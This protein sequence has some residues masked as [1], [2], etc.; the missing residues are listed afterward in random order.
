MPKQKTLTTEEYGKMASYLWDG[1]WLQGSRGW[2]H[3]PSCMASWPI[4]EAY[5]MAKRDEADGRRMSAEDV[6]EY[7]AGR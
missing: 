4:E 3:P 6:K 5:A 1:G 2:W 7:L